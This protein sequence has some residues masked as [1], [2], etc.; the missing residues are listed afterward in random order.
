[1]LEWVPPRSTHAGATPAEFPQ[2]S[3]AGEPGGALS[4]HSMPPSFPHRR[5]S[6]K[7]VQAQER[8]R[9]GRPWGRVSLSPDSR[10][11]RAP[12]SLIEPVTEAAGPASRPSPRRSR[13]RERCPGREA[14]AA[15]RSHKTDG[16]VR[17]SDPVNPAR[18][19]PA[20]EGDRSN[21]TG[22][23]EGGA[24]AG[25]GAATGDRGPGLARDSGPSPVRHRREAGPP[26]PHP[27]RTPLP[28]KLVC[29][30]PGTRPKAPQGR[31]KQQAHARGDGPAGP[32]AHGPGRRPPGRRPLRLDGPERPVY[33]VPGAGHA[34][35]S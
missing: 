9:G 10:W 35:Q 15:E 31:L 6:F 33:R 30:H 8:T 14:G 28:G 26:R 34:G 24:K 2:A 23:K 11:L 12:S 27:K 13:P 16:A 29:R 1:M 7:F 5:V 4:V 19:P 3:D 20:P 21:I 22:C 32:G 18:C 17:A 25:S